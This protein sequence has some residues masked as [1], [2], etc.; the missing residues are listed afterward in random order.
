MS[1]T[2]R[3][4][5]IYRSTCDCDMHPAKTSVEQLFKIKVDDLF[6]LIF[7]NNIFSQNVHEAQHLIGI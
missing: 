4:K 5:D 2:E 7:G 3:K 6:E 1:I